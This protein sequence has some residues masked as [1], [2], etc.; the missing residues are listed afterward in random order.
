VKITKQR[1]R[2]IIKEELG[3]VKEARMRWDREIAAAAQEL[4]APAGFVELVHQALLSAAADQMD[5]A[6]RELAEALGMLLAG[7]QTGELE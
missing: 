4:G 7:A 5:Q 6:Q 1:L 2:E 3:T